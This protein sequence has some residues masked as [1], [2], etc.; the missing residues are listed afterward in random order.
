[1]WGRE[2][3]ASLASSMRSR[4]GKPLHLWRLGS[5]PREEARDVMRHLRCP[6]CYAERLGRSMTAG[7]TSRLG[8]AR[9]RWRSSGAAMARPKWGASRTS[10]YVLEEGRQPAYMQD[11]DEVSPRVSSVGDRAATGAG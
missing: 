11:C 3:A 4:H 5:R 7:R 2:P 9:W 8:G 10:R 1:W 6:G